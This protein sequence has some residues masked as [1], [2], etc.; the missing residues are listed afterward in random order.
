MF[1][2][3]A[4]VLA[5]SQASVSL[6]DP[7]YCFTTDPIHPQNQMFATK[8]VYEALHGREIPNVS[9]C[10]PRKFWMYSRHGTR[11]PSSSDIRR[12]IDIHDRLQSS[13]LRN[14]DLGRTQLCRADYENIANWI[15]N[16]TNLDPDRN[17]ELVEAGCE[18]LRGIAQRFQKAFP[19]ILP[20]TY[21]T[22]E[23]LIRFT[24][25]QRTQASLDA[26]AEDLF[27]EG[28][29]NDI[30]FEPVP[31]VDRLLRPHDDCPLYDE[32]SSNLVE[33]EAFE[34][35]P[36]FQQIL[37]QVNKNLDF[38]DQINFQVEKF[39]RYYYGMGYGGQERLF[40]NMNC[41]IMHDLLTYLQSTNPNDQLA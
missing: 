9:T 26:F 5:F 32:V 23:F 20:K 35:G 2:I 24:D 37:E 28:A 7:F 15:F 17:S 10:T 14:Y 40:S 13:V 1:T 29:H 4:I 36:D 27:D 33:Q 19:N 34:E 39:A 12:M 16:S 25:R 11:L 41:H 18:E 22:S 30:F 6:H 31:A 3:L 38:S 21:N 8:V